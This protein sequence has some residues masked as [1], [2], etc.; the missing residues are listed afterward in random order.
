VRRDVTDQDVADRA[1]VPS[2][3]EVDA[4]TDRRIDHERPFG[5]TGA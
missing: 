3:G 4:G 1:E 2:A 5:R